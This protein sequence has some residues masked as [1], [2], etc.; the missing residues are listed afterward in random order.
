VATDV[1]EQIDRLYGLGQGEFTAERDALAKSLRK[2]DRAAADRVKSLRK[3][4]TAAWAVNQVAR[5]RPKLVS[6]LLRAGETLR[7]AQAGML[8]GGDRDAVRRSVEDEREWV[9]RIVEEAR[10]C[11]SRGDGKATQATV[12]AVRQTLHAAATSDEV[13]ELVRSGRLVEEHRAAGFGLGDLASVPS[14]PRSMP[15]SESKPAPKPKQPSKAEERKRREAEK[16]LREQ[17]AAAK[18]ELTAARRE[19][20][21]AAKR[22]ERAEAAAARAQ[23]ALDKA[24]EALGGAR[25]ETARR[26]RALRDAEAAAA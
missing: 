23:N 5:R 11:L 13:R 15:K 22:M 12:D 1:D 7:E 18:K 19:E 16:R 24:A 25:E 6:E 4:V 10:A 17:V 8:S 14:A 26:E 20:R 9:D 21:D 2:E 3:P